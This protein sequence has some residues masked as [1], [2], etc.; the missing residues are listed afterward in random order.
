MTIIKHECPDW[1][2]MEIDY[3][4]SEMSG[5]SCE[6]RLPEQ[7]RI[8]VDAR[9]RA[10]ALLDAWNESQSDAAGE[11]NNGSPAITGTKS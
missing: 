4:D 6:F 8:A 7:Q 9:E 2:F 5:C 1:D 3:L 10:L 11:Q